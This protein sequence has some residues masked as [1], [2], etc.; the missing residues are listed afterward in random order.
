M[1]EKCKSLI[2]YNL[3]NLLIYEFI[4]LLFTSLVLVPPI[5][6]LYVYINR[7]NEYSIPILF[8][9]ALLISFSILL[10]IF[11]K[12]SLITILD[13]S[14]HK[15]KIS[16]SEM[17]DISIYKM[18]KIFTSDNY[19]LL[20]LYVMFIPLLYLTF[21]GYSVIDFLKYQSISIK[22]ISIIIGIY[23]IIMIP[24]LRYVYSLHYVV[25]D[26]K[27]LK[28][29]RKFSARL[30][31]N[32]LEKDIGTIIVF[33]ALM[34]PLLLVIICGY[35][36]L[37][38]NRPS[39]YIINGLVWLIDVIVI[40]IYVI[41]SNS[42]ISVLFYDH[43]KDNQEKCLQI[44][45]SSNA[46]QNRLV[47][48]TVVFVS[49]V[50]SALLCYNYVYQS[51]T[52]DN[53]GAIRTEITAHRGDDFNY[54]ENTMA[55]F[56]GAKEAN[57]EWIELDVRQT[58]D[59]KLVVYHDGNL[60][61]LTGFNKDVIN[62]TYDEIK[63]LD[64]GSFFDKRFAGEK[65]PLFE[66]AVKFAKENGIKLNVELKTTFREIDFE[67]QVVSI[68][69][70]YGYADSCVV[71][72]PTYKQ[73]RKVKR[74]NP[75]IKTA[76][77]VSEVTNED[78]IYLDDIDAISVDVLKVNGYLIDQV[79]KA[80]KEIYVWTLNDEKLMNEMIALSVDN[81]ITD[82]VR[83]ANKLVEEWKDKLNNF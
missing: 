1:I 4:Y 33:Q 13:K 9:I 72:A 82:N 48:K 31:E 47:P 54:P 26:E 34:L 24:L 23:L 77:L 19:K 16:I 56:K 44:K 15:E 10:L 25:I 53:K 14:K 52:A 62:T 11:N 51:F 3:K 75:N 37:I 5:I 28:N 65:I 40:T 68:I 45:I 78:I 57:A 27:K 59:Q 66:E 67:K 32:N 81:I 6:F 63:D 74:L 64:C 30:V 58:K 42:L 21:A 69:D 41:C 18:S 49:I 20:F 36:E 8:I 83:L 73:L 17:L 2:K 71:E 50:F 61:R 46:K 7:N 29:A 60:N 70:K 43:K 39:N 22:W 35:N 38:M 80:G 55:A 12:I 79:H 76:L